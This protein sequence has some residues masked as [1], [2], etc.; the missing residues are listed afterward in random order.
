MD[1]LVGLFN[2][3]GQLLKNAFDTL[4]D[5]A[6]MAFAESGFSGSLFE[7]V[8]M[9]ACVPPDAPGELFHFPQHGLAM[10]AP[11]FG[12]ERATNSVSNPDAVRIS[13][14]RMSRSRCW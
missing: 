2:S 7:D 12:A 5:L 1:T 11:F 9:S 10:F 8:E 13:S 4:F 6:D 3:G 14:M